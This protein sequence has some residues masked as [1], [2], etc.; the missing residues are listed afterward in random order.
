MARFDQSLVPLLALSF[1]GSIAC[2]S[3]TA[4]GTPSGATS[5]DASSE[6][7]DNA[8]A[9]GSDGDS[10]TDTDTPSTSSEDDESTP[11]EDDED[12]TSAGDDPPSE[13]ASEG[14]DDTPQNTS[15][16]N[17]P[18]TASIE[19]APASAVAPAQ[20]RFDDGASSDSDGTIVDFGW[21]FADGTEAT[22]AEVEH[23]FAGEGCFEVE[24]TVT[25]NA[26]ASGTAT[27]TVVIVNDIA[28]GDP[29][30]SL[31]VAPLASAVLPRDLTT[32]EAIAHFEGTVNSLGY[33]F[34]LAE[35][36]AGEI[37]ISTTTVPLCGP[38]PITFSLDAMIPAVLV[39]HDVRISLA[40]GDTVTEIA[41]VPDL[42]AGDLYVIQ[43]Q[44]NAVA[45]RYS[46][47]A[48]PGN[49]GPFV[50]SFGTNAGED[51]AAA[52]DTIWRIANGDNG[53]GDGGI[54]QWGLRMAAVLSAETQVPLG[55]L[56]GGKGGRPITYFQRN[57]EDHADLSTNYG[58]LLTRLTAAGIDQDIRAFL[59]YQGESDQDNFMSHRAGFIALYEDWRDDYG[60]VDRTY[61]TQIRSGCGGTWVGVKNVQ[62]NLAD[63]Y[64]AITVMSTTALNGHEGCHYAF[65]N[66]YESLGDRYA[67]LLGRDL[68]GL[69]PDA[70]VEPPNPKLA[71]FTDA[72]A[73]VV[74]TMRNETSELTYQDG[75]HADFRLENA[76]GITVTGGSVQGHQLI[77]RLS[78]DGSAATG[79]TNLGH[80]KAGQWVT[81]ENGVGL[82]TFFALPIE[83]E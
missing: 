59:W 75:A 14:D 56:N 65:A 11:S 49:Q 42:V 26:G 67:A 34:A 78:G 58:R 40:V 39:S 32:N 19:L 70:D 35:V 51:A 69:V 66:G 3:G 25:D 27:K 80:A 16:P 71:R 81:N 68:Y 48:N 22:G 43:G 18:P 55:L 15:P 7:H 12:P 1:T 50:R 47:D 53:G 52:A 64:E 20:V 44:S 79:I 13:N 5:G 36:L 77:L 73:A 4:A 29:D 17:E 6:S 9:A 33:A 41:R 10:N 31:H 62:R 72:G 24:L 57:D 82:L 61:I 76:P 38:A 60:E 8:S 54:G 30:A 46:G 21:D 23:A 74:V 28:S 2:V 83:P 63:E 45:R 37:V